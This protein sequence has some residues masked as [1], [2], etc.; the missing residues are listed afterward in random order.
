M[1]SNQPKVPILRT[2]LMDINNHIQLYWWFLM[3]VHICS[4]K[5]RL[6]L[7]RP[8]FPVASSDFRNERT[9]LRWFVTVVWHVQLKQE[10]VQMFIAKSIQKLTQIRWNS[11]CTEGRPRRN[12]MRASAVCSE[13]SFLFNRYLVIGPTGGETRL[14]NVCGCGAL[15]FSSSPFVLTR[16]RRELLRSSRS[17]LVEPLVVSRTVLHVLNLADWP[18]FSRKKCCHSP[19]SL[20]STNTYNL[21]V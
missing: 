9:L 12:T 11:E 21:L 16:S 3:E 8:C 10:Y 17:P 19:P 14:D 18:C 7:W 6:N 1:H 4:S 5:V 13:F 20:Y 2:L 15:S